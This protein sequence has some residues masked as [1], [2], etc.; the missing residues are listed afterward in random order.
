MHNEEPLTAEQWTALVREVHD[1]ADDL[2]ARFVRRVAAIPPYRRGTVPLERVEADAV[3]SFDYLLRRLGGLPVSPRLAGIGPSIGRDRARRGVPLEHLLTAVRLDFRVLW[4]A[5]R[6]T[7]GPEHTGLLVERA[8]EVWETVEDYTT[9]IQVSY[10]EESALMSRERQRE[11]AVWMRTLLDQADPDPQDVNRAAL[12]LDVDPEAAFLVAAVPA[13]AD[14]EL[15]AVADQLVAAGRRVHLDESPR[16]TTLIVR[17]RSEPADTAAAGALLRGVGCGLAPVVDGLAAVPR[18]ARIA[19]QI[20]DVLPLDAAAP[21]ELVDAWA[22]LVRH[23]L[24]DLAAPLTDAAIGG[25]DAA[26]PPE[27]ER[28]SQT[29]LAYADTGSVQA[30]AD[31]LYCHRN[32]VLNRLRRLHELTGLDVTRP[33]DAALLLVC[34]LNPARRTAR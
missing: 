16:H 10:L 26:A 17:W 1:R 21:V 29:L 23:G 14:K 32:T 19:Q 13:Q 3:T 9:T 30:A 15:R 18:A 28:L 2:V 24:G 20:S 34:G 27:R 22:A 4:S 7:S 5:L 31:R 33:R 25:L 6:E 11:R 8:E 12:A